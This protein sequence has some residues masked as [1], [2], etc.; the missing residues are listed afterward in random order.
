MG[1]SQGSH[2]RV[3]RIAE[4]SHEGLSHPGD[5]DDG[6]SSKPSLTEFLLIRVFEKAEE[7]KLL[8]LRALSPDLEVAGHFPVHCLPPAATGKAGRR[9]LTNGLERRQYL[10]LYVGGAVLEEIGRGNRSV[11]S[12]EVDDVPGEL[13]GR[14][15]LFGQ[16]LGSGSPTSRFC[17][18][19]RHNLDFRV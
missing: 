12:L 13:V 17:P 4:D 8:P 1:V 2:L 14:L 10:C 16:M 15:L 18:T 6:W 7:A 19:S 9:C 5:S 11:T 3:I